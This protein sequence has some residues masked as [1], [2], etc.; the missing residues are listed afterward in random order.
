MFQRPGG[1]R[2]DA[3]QAEHT[4]QVVIRC[5]PS[6]AGVTMAKQ[7]PSPK[8]GVVAQP[9]VSRG[10]IGWR[11]HPARFRVALL[12]VAAIDSPQ[13]SVRAPRW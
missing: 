8:V 2:R 10:G 13:F 12:V 1:V 6:I 5:R 9:P 3:R 11:W 7:K 4:G